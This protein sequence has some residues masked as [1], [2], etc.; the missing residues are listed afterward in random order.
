MTVDRVGEPNAVDFSTEVPVNLRTVHVL[1]HLLTQRIEEQSPIP[2]EMHPLHSSLA[3][4]LDQARAALIE[5][6]RHDNNTV[7]LP[8]SLNADLTYLS[9][10][11][12]MLAYEGFRSQ[13][14]QDDGVMAVYSL[15][16]HMR[17][18]LDARQPQGGPQ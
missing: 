10:Q 17:T 14:M 5:G 7:P 1:T 18:L 4:R 13:Q 12:V 3:Y 8:L 15:A 9:L 11:G 2:P 6:P 16:T